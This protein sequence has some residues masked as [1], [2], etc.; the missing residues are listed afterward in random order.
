MRAEPKARKKRSSNIFRTRFKPAESLIS[1][2]KSRYTPS[3]VEGR[4][5]TAAQTEKNFLEELVGDT[6]E[7]SDATVQTDKIFDMPLTKTPASPPPILIKMGK[8]ASTQV[9]PGEL[10]DF[11]AEVEPV[12]ESLVGKVLE[13]VRLT[14]QRFSSKLCEC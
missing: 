8:D 7:Y 6:E 9:L 4:L 11:E 10:F 12:L 14:L 13:Q 3:P 2:T 1:S 5:H